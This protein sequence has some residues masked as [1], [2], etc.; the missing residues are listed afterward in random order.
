M[1]KTTETKPK[2]QLSKEELA[3]ISELEQGEKMHKKNAPQRHEDSVRNDEEVEQMRKD[4]AEK[5]SV[6]TSSN[7]ERKALRKGK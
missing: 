7:E 5:Q 6:E 1:A 3:A 2:V 4:V